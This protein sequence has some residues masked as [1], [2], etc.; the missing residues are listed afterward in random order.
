MAMEGVVE[1][2]CACT[3]LAKAGARRGFLTRGTEQREGV[4][5]RGLAALGCGLQKLADETGEL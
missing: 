4:V 2:T 1:R 5:E 3:A